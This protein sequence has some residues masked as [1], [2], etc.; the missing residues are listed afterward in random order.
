MA[1][2]E[3]DP[4]LKAGCH[5]DDDGIAIGA[6]PEFATPALQ[7]DCLQ[8]LEAL[9]AHAIVSITDASGVIVHANDKFCEISGY[10][11][12][13]LLGQDHRLLNSGI[14]PQ[15]F[16][17]EMWTTI[18]G[19][20]HWQGLICN[21]TRNGSLYWVNSS[22]V[23]ILDSAGNVARYVSIRTDVSPLIK[24]QIQVRQSEQDFRAIFDNLQDVF[25]RT[26]TTGC[27]TQLSPSV[28]SQ[29][30]YNPEELVGKNIGDLWIEPEMRESFLQ[31]LHENGGRVAGY[32]ASLRRKDG[33]AIWVSASSHLNLDEDGNII[34][35]E[36][37]L[38]DISQRK[39]L[40]LD[41]MQAKEEAEAANKAKSTFLA[42][43]S[44]E[45]RTPLNAILGFSQILEME[46]LDAD[47]QDSVAHIHK[48]GRHLLTLINEVLDLSSIEAGKIELSLE[49]VDVGSLFDEAMGAIAPLAQRKGIELGYQRPGEAL[50]VVADRNRMHQVVLNLVSNAIKYNRPQGKVE[51]YAE[52][53]TDRVRISVS[54]TGIGM[55]PHDLEQLFMPYARFGPRHIEGTGIGLTIT[56]RLVEA[57]GG[58]IGV[59]SEQDVGSTFWIEFKHVH[60]GGEQVAASVPA[61]GDAAVETPAM[62]GTVLYIEDD[63]ANR[64]MLRMALRHVPEMHLIAADNPH[65]GLTLAA[66]HLPDLI[67]LDITMPE[68]NGFEVFER[69]RG[70][71]RTR[72]IPVVAVSAN[73]MPEYLEKAREA[74][75]NEYLTKPVNITALLTTV[76]Q[77]LQQL[78][79]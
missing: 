18:Q 79:H 55:S 77:H 64:E 10:A 8:Q 20:K 76:K 36:G 78:T 60:I 54:D 63:H 25:Y 37:I 61:V 40:E 32:E 45:L 38:R 67:L 59:E 27:I 50:G 19:G 39:Q 57:M 35:V 44:H 3:H 16:F 56:R 12:E 33:Q 13:E 71:S 26:D 7:Q 11:R 65:K 15:T 68:M 73:A 14:H 34:G 46:N 5:S 17:S 75:F 28:E 43:M 23:P 6:R 62:K 1:I 4:G 30:Q 49:T 24:A 29:L 22:I 48:A 53:N 21:R 58:T 69:L 2:M 51:I 41:L 47:I 74:G 9:N 42:S 70:D 66:A 72:H 52:R 31:Q